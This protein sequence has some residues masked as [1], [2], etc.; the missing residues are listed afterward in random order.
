MPR[1]LVLPI[2]A[3]L[4]LAASYAHA[5]DSNP[6]LRSEFVFTD[7]PFASCHAATI[8][9]TPDGTLVAAWFAGTKEGANDVAIWSAR[10]EKNAE[11]WSA[12]ELVGNADDETVPCWNPVLFQP[13]DGPLYL[14]YKQGRKIA[15]WQGVLLTS[16]DSGRTWRDRRV[17]PEFFIGPVKNKPVEL[18]DGSCLAPS[19][20]EHDGWRVHFEFIPAFD[21]TWSRTEAINNKKEC[22]AIQPTILIHNDGRL[23]ALC[24]NRNGAASILQTWSEDSGRTW[25]K[26]E[27]TALPNPNSGIDAVT[28]QDGR[29]LLVYNHTNVATG[30]RNMLNVAVSDDGLN[31]RAVAILENSSGEYSYPAVIQARDGAVHILYTWR[32]TRV[33]RVVLDPTKIVGAPIVDGVWPEASALL[34][35]QE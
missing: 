2:L 17:L 3:S 6:I 10:L 32:R 35:A 12:P 11:R 18:A 31:W 26:L 5:D 33:R 34:P 27:P 23:Q 25:S 29:F 4:L 21:K 9:E 13:K 24:R 22:G 19:S 20:T 7:A 15:E 28:L 8:A 1:Y 30:G 14:F 16:Y